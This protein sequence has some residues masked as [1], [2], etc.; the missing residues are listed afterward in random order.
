MEHQ[1]VE[2]L[3]ALIRERPTIYGPKPR[4]GKK[5]HQK[6]LDA[7]W[8][9]VAV[10]MNRP[11]NQCK[12]KWTTLRNCYARLLREERSQKV[13]KR[14]WHLRNDMNFLRGFIQ[15]YSETKKNSLRRTISLRR[16]LS[17]TDMSTTNCSFDE[18]TSSKPIKDPI[19][20][21]CVSQ[22][23]TISQE[24]HQPQ[25]TIV[26][27]SEQVTNNIWQP[28]HSSIE[29]EHNTNYSNNCPVI[30]VNPFN[31]TERIESTE[32]NSPTKSVDNRS[33]AN[34][35]FLKSLLP[36]VN[37][38]SERKQRIFKRKT[39]EILEMLFDEGDIPRDE[40]FMRQCQMTRSNFNI[41]QQPVLQAADKFVT[42]VEPLSP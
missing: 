42:K 40:S 10:E 6:V 23:T 27:T 25:F 11:V 15:P 33:E 41:Q 17:T 14:H 29:N 18:T 8:S 9:E 2:K 4:K 24:H 21:K 16:Q 35:L 39:L 38:L 30:E 12:L 37:K 28:E 22:D 3:I 7:L 34:S 1:N 26:E 19:I 20:V 5:K 31:S 32:K 13:K 36:D